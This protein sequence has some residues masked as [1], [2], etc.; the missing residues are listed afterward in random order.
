MHLV[1]QNGPKMMWTLGPLPVMVAA[2]SLQ[3]NV[4]MSSIG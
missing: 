2:N 3:M 4:D 1:M